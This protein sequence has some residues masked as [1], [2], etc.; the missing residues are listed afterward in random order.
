MNSYTGIIGT[1]VSGTF[2]YLIAAL[3]AVILCSIIK[4]FRGMR[5]GTYSDQELDRQLDSRGL[6]NRI[7]GGYARRIDEP[8]KTYPVGVLFGPGFD[9]ATEVAL[10]VL[11]GTAVAGGLCC[12]ARAGPGSRGAAAP[13]G[14]RAVRGQRAGLVWPGAPHAAHQPAVPG[15]ER[16]ARAGPGRRAAAPGAG[17][18]PLQPGRDRRLPGA[19]RCPADGLAADAGGRASLPGRRRLPRGT[20][21]AV[22]ARHQAPLRPG[23]SRV[24][25]PECWERE[26]QPSRSPS[27]R[28]WATAW[29]RVATPSFR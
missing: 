26:V 6:M 11:A 8:W 15:P 1:S 23:I 4:V 21:P 29:L 10:L 25:S 22:F 5:T 9:T 17:Q 7:F 27:S 13:V 18:G 24:A 3:N 19:G 20:V 2:L 12:P 28:A 14:D 16:S